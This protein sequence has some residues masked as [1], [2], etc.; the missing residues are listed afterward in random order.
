MVV[1]SVAEEELFG[2]TREEV[3]KELLKMPGHN[4]FRRFN[5]HLAK[6]EAE[7]AAME[8]QLKKVETWPRDKRECSALALPL[9]SL[10][11]SPVPAAIFNPFPHKRWKGRLLPVSPRCPSYRAAALYHVRAAL[12]W[13]GATGGRGT[14]LYGKVQPAGGRVSKCK[15]S[16]ALLRCGS[17]W[18][19]R[20]WGWRTS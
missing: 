15:R 6:T 4:D 9:A 17:T 1:G 20:A 11:P 19:W 3:E 8:K 13:A 5:T 2:M 16:T 12:F 7:W 10:Q 18:C 14:V